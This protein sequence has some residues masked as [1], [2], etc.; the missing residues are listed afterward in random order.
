[1]WRLVLPPLL[2]ACALAQPLPVR[3]DELVAS[4]WK[5][6]IELSKG[7]CILPIGILEKHGP[8]LPI[9]ADLIGAQHR[10]KEAARQEYA[11]VFPEY[12]WGQIYEAKYAEG[13]VALPP[14]L[15]SELLQ[16]TLDEIARNGF[17]KILIYSTHGGNPH[18]LRFWVQTQLE[19]RRDYVV[20]LFDPAPDPEYLKTFQSQ[21]F[22]K[23]PLA[24]DEHA[25]EQ[26]TSRI[27]AIRP[28]IVKLERAP[29][30]DSSDQKRL[31]HLPDI[32]TATSWYARFPNH[33]AGVGAAASAE[34]GRFSNAH[35]TRLLVEAIRNVKAD[36][37]TAK[38]QKEN[39]DRQLR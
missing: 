34:E 9:G 6:A 22:R 26:E 13:T 16:A 1:M 38:I 35:V 14:H 31:A 2:A 4:D 3:W 28:D 39:Y 12:Y 5:K 27:M 24:G 32:W 11:V 36:E 30:E 19:K 23:T 10:A 7:T 33:Y 21:S 15:I 20:Y 37:T 18:W 17:K 25:G 29:R 8:H